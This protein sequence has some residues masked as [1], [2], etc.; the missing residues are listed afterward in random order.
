VVDIIKSV[1]RFPCGLEELVN[2]DLSSRSVNLLRLVDIV[3]GTGTGTGTGGRGGRD[4]NALVGVMACQA[5]LY[6]RVY[7]IDYETLLLF[8]VGGENGDFDA[9]GKDVKSK[10]K[11]R[12][13]KGKMT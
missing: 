7:V 3:L 10:K 13:E 12:K 5:G 2:T 6:A 9:D 11:G 8:L 4:F 1:G